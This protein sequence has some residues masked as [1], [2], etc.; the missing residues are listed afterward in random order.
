MDLKP[1][2]IAPRTPPQ[3]SP[4]EPWHHYLTLDLVHRVLGYTLFHPFVAWVLVLCLRAQATPYEHVEMRIAIAWAL[5]MSALGI[6]AIASDRIAFGPPRDVDVDDE[7]L[8]VTGGCA[9]L[10]ALIADVYGMR[11]ATVAVLDTEPPRDADADD[12]GIVFYRCDVGDAAQVEQAAKDIVQ[13][14][15]RSTTTASHAD[16]AA[17]PAHDPDQQRRRRPRQARPR[18]DGGRRG[19]VRHSECRSAPAHASSVFRTNTLAHFHTLRAFLPHMLAARRGTVVTVS[20]VLAH[21]GAANL[22]AYAASKAA[23]LALHASLRAEL[24][25]HPAGPDIKTILVTPGQIATPMFAAVPTPSRFLAPIV[26]P[27]DVAKE[28]VA[29]LDRG[30]GGEV[31][32]PLYARW[33]PLL[34]VLPA[35]VQRLVR[36]WSGVDRAVPSGSLNTRAP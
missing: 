20:S 18:D 29:L 2:P 31:A 3:S 5:L 19:A 4:D 15:R 12:K 1:T 10:G 11:G 22:A 13:D 17:G 6:A 7:V 27:T 23:L 25:Q 32:V 28:L 14:V 21:V 34:A 16:L 24:A 33:I 8:V 9:G 30:L 35:G 26:P 36:A